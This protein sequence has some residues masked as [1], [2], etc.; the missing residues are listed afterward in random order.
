M[1]ALHRNTGLPI[2]SSGL[3]ALPDPH[4]DMPPGVLPAAGT[5][6]LSVRRVGTPPTTG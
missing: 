5:Y 2:Q 4:A 3:I 1:P 6:Y